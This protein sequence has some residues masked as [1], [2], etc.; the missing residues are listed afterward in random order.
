MRGSRAG[1]QGRPRLGQ[2]LRV[3]L[4]LG[5]GEV[6]DGGVARHKLPFKKLK[7]GLGHSLNNAVYS[8]KRSARKH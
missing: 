4:D 1:V 7:T 6:D 2:R 5:D 3:Q 8:N